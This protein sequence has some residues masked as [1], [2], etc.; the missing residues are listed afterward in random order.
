MFACVFND[1]VIQSNAFTNIKVCTN[2]SKKTLAKQVPP[3]PMNNSASVLS[4]GQLSFTSGT[5]G[6]T[7]LIL[8]HKQNTL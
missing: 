8:V 7:C 1:F 3:S 2:K 5:H 6:Y 4:V